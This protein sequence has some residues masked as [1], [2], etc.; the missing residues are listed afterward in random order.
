MK[1]PS[2]YLKMRVLGAIEGAPGRTS[3]ERI[4]HVA[5]LV[6]IDEEGNPRQFTWRTIQTWL[7][8]Y[9]NHGITSMG[10]N[11]RKDK[12]KTRKITPEELMAAI[13]SALP[14][15]HNKRYNKTDVYR[16][17]IETGLLRKEQLAPTTYYRFVREYDLFSKDDGK[18]RLAFAMQ[19]ANQMW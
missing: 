3:H 15:F 14:H 10:V 7:Y 8:R 6:F 2:S 17:C 12:G 5:G 9:R 1:Q 16:Y 11:P 4:L 18:K 19:Y 13:N